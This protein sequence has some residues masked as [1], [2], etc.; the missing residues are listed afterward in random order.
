[1]DTTELTDYEKYIKKEY[2]KYVKA[3]KEPTTPKQYPFGMDEKKCT[4]KRINVGNIERDGEILLLQKFN[5]N[6][7]DAH[8]PEEYMG[9]VIFLRTGAL[10]QPCFIFEKNK[11]K[12][13]IPLY[14]LPFFSKNEFDNEEG[15]IIWRLYLNSQTFKKH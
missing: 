9:T 14:S 12:D 10:T 7:R 13:V 11:I 2:D 3:I 4:W 15:Y 5:I 1:M 8:I 6:C